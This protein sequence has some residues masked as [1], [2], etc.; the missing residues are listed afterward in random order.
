MP[1]SGAGYRVMKGPQE[2]LYE[3]SF[4]PHGL[5]TSASGDASLSARL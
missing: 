1:S 4:G 3:G 2:A 5:S